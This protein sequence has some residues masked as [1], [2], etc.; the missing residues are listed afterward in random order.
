MLKESRE[1]T[2]RLQT[3]QMKDLNKD[4]KQEKTTVFSCRTACTFAA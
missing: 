2:Q 4:E 3:I 1:K